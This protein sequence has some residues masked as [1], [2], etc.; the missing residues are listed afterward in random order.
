VTARVLPDGMV[1]DPGGFPFV[2]LATNSEGHRPRLAFGG[3]QLLVVA[4]AV[5][6]TAGAGPD[7]FFLDKDGRNPVRVTPQMTQMTGGTFDTTWNGT[8]FIVVWQGGPGVV[9]ARLSTAGVWLDSG[10]AIN[11]PTVMP[12][13]YVGQAIATTP[14]TTFVVYADSTFPGGVVRLGSFGSDGSSEMLAPPL[15]T[16]ATLQRVR[17]AAH[18]DGQSLVVWSEEPMETEGASLLAVRVSDLGTVL[19]PTPIVLASRITASPFAGAAW[20]QNAFLVAWWQGTFP[21]QTVAGVRVDSTGNVLDTAPVTI[22]GSNLLTPPISVVVS[23]STFLVST[24]DSNSLDPH[25]SGT[26]S[27]EVVSQDLKSQSAVQIGPDMPEDVIA[28]GTM[29]LNNG[30]VAV[31]S[32]ESN[33]GNG[34]Q[35]S[36]IGSDGTSASG[37]TLSTQVASWLALAPT[38]I[39][40]LLWMNGNAGL[41]MSTQAPFEAGSM[42]AVPRDIGVPTWVGSGFVAVNVT[43][44]DVMLPGPQYLGLAVSAMGADGSLQDPPATLV[45]PDLAVDAWS[46]VALG[47]DRALVAYSRLAPDDEDGTQRAFFQIVDRSLASAGGAGADGSA[48]DVEAGAEVSPTDGGT[49]GSTTDA[50]EAAGDSTGAESGVAGS[51]SGGGCDVGAPATGHRTPALVLI[52]LAIGCRRRHSWRRSS[53]EGRS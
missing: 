40:A 17:A 26:P 30:F 11:P 37:G 10:V 41:F 49:D 15:E 28:F 6:A 5:D 42:F 12:S 22:G 19:D 13:P 16:A 53:P 34:I 52:V 38:P 48:V 44:S 3:G 29:G 32:N 2:Q 45:S 7:V 50:Q 24:G 21:T 35:V 18:G 1:L 31:W 39:G 25:T 8:E 33:D 46:T 43:G 23:S 14:T 4:G 9:A 36:T 51:G 47:S 27:F 20:G